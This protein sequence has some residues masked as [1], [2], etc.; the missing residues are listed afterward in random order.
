[1]HAFQICKDRLTRVQETLGQ[2]F[3]KDGEKGGSGSAAGV[4]MVKRVMQA[5]PSADG[6]EE[7]IRFRAS[8]HLLDRQPNKQ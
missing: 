3:E 2:Y 5:E 6:E 7:D 1:M 8:S 4:G